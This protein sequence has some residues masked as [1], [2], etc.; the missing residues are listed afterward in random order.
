MSLFGYNFAKHHV[1]KLATGKKF[2]PAQLKKI[3]IDDYFMARRAE[4]SCPSPLTNTVLFLTDI[5]EEQL[6][7]HIGKS[8]GAKTY[9]FNKPYV[10][11]YPDKEANKFV[12]VQSLTAV[13]IVTNDERARFSVGATVVFAPTVTLHYGRIG[14]QPNQMEEK[15]FHLD[16]TSGF[17]MLSH[18]HFDFT[19]G[20]K[21]TLGLGT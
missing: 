11:K 10:F 17:G 15:V 12:C 14:A 7:G 21:T 16:E 3:A 20:Q 13:V 1:H 5:E 2:Q 19:E 18:K 6:N 9:T 4:P 8:K